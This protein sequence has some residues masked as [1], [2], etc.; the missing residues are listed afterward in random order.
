ML[1]FRERVREPGVAN[2]ELLFLC[3][4]TGAC[5]VDNLPPGDLSILLLRRILLNLVYPVSDRFL[6][7]MAPIFLTLMPS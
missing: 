1:P 4:T 6:P 7:W 3:F 2:R 5:I